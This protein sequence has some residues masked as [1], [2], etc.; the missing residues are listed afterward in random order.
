MAEVNPPVVSI[1]NRGFLRD[2]YYLEADVI[3]DD[4]LGYSLLWHNG[5]ITK[6]IKL[7]NETS[8][9]VTATNRNGSITATITPLFDADNHEILY[10]VDDVS[11]I[12][13]KWYL[14]FDFKASINDIK[15]LI[16]I[17]SQLD[18]NTVAEIGVKAFGVKKTANDPIVYYN[19]DTPLLSNWY[20]VLLSVDRN[21]RSSTMKITQSSNTVYNNT[22][23]IQNDFIPYQIRY[24]TRHN[25][26]DGCSYGF[27]IDNLQIHK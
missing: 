3:S 10:T 12:P 27:Y 11:I 15:P 24:E 16:I 20:H 14:E 2:G 17:K 18:S 8:A 26:F 25:G 19:Y 13:N 4:P 6:T 5:A 7:T 22:I 1:I 9:S 21:A 23:T